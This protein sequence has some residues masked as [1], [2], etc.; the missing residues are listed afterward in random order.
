MIIS[1]KILTL[2]AINAD[3]SAQNYDCSHSL[4]FFNLKTL[5]FLSQR[6]TFYLKVPAFLVGSLTL[7]FQNFDFI[8]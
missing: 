3:I 2:L 7:T 4:D 6:F 1:F 8:S 5:T